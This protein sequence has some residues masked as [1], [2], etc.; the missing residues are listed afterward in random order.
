MWHFY[1]FVIACM[2]C[3]G[4]EEPVHLVITNDVSE[5]ITLFWVDMTATPPELIPIIDEI[6][7]QMSE[8]VDSYAGHQFVVKIVSNASVGVQFM[9]GTINENIVIRYY[10]DFGMTASHAGSL[11][12]FSTN[13]VKFS[14]Q[15]ES[16]FQPTG[17]SNELPQKVELK[18]K[19]KCSKPI[20]VIWNGGAGSQVLLA[21]V[22]LDKA[23]VLGT[24]DTH[25]FII[26]FQ[27]GSAGETEFSKG[28]Y[29]E[30]LYVY[31]DALAGFDVEVSHPF[32]LM[33]DALMKAIDMCPADQAHP[34]HAH[35]ITQHTFPGMQQIIDQYDDVKT[36]RD[37]ISDKLRNY[38][39]SDDSMQ[40]STPI[41]S[42]EEFVYDREV[43]VDT[44]M[45]LEHAKIW[46]VHE[47]ISEDEC[48][49][50][51]EYSRPRL[52]RAA[53]AGE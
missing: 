34:L 46:T 43:T 5:S 38:S 4:A 22:Q 23:A 15:L 51:M 19:N 40:T 39:C 53:V 41:S 2:L 45:R 17:Q 49:L 33:E 8:M 16:K 24:F 37:K 6:R 7:P 20:E 31:H 25:K 35:C 21:V 29:D 30:I 26:K 14:N 52:E 1:V 27:D 3:I 50:L 9:K 36:Y 18:V 32:S 10:D 11:T 47:F 12:E 13:R 28:P 48:E 44:Y 42:A